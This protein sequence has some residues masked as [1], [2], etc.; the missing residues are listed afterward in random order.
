VGKSAVATNKLLCFE[1]PEWAHHGIQIRQRNRETR[2]NPEPRRERAGTEER[3][4][5]EGG[6]RVGDY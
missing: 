2:D 4:K 1:I 3:A 6:S 5:G